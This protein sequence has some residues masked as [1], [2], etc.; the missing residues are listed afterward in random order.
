MAAAEKFGVK[1]NFHLEPYPG[2]TALKVRDDLKYILEQYGSSPAFYRDPAR[3]NRPLYYVYDSYHTPKEE[4]R[5]LLSPGGRHTVR[6][7]ELDADFISLYLSE[8]DNNFIQESGF[9]GIY[10]YFASK[11]FTFASNP[12]NW[13][14]IAQWAKE[15]NK[16]FI[17]CVAPGYEDTWLRYHLGEGGSRGREY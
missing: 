2:R 8:N 11:T 6:S 10:T 15:N 12:N 9:D 16:V 13:P 1:V 7:T 14:R 4:W 5:E 17:P 3:S